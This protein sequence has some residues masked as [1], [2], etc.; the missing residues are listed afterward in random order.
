[1]VCQDDHSMITALTPT[2]FPWLDASRYT[3]SLGVSAGD[4]LWLAGETGATY[5]PEGAE[6]SDD[7]GEQATVAWDKIAAVLAAG[8]SEPS[9]CT[10]AVEYVT[11]AGLLAQKEIAAARPDRV[12]PVST[13]VVEALVRPEPQVEIEVVAGGP[14]GHF[15][16]PQILPV[17]ESGAVVAPGDYVAQTEFVLQRAGQLLADRGLD[18]SNIVRLVEQMTP[19]CRR[20]IRA[21]GDAR[22]NL[23]GPEFP[24][25]T[26]VLV[27]ALPRDDVLIALDVCASEH[28]KEVIN[29]GWE[30]F[31]DLTFSPAVRA[32]DLLYIAGTPAW[33]PETNETVA[34]GDIETQARFVYEQIGIV[35]E[36]AGGSLS[37]LVKT[38]EYVTP[39][40]MDNYR[41]VGG[42]RKELLGRPYPAATGVVVSGLMSRQWVIEVE[43]IAVLT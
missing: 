40:A 21:T 25:S 30:A 22:K 2:H 11:A 32:G 8:D 43:A 29:P 18:Q 10:E 20:E 6:I 23:L 36:A 16:F 39:A 24:A 38:V 42:I 41:A 35:C 33:N 28:P 9:A 4:A 26:G 1:M 37:N 27:P 13:M 5:G 15:R 17:E 3:F 19:E 7:I 31:D 14:P 12:G 34:A